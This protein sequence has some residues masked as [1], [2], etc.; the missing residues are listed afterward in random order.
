MGIYSSNPIM[1]I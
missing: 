1:K